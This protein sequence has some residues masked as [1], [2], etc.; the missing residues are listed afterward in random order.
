MTNY[1]LIES[2]DAFEARDNGGFCSDLAAS[3]S[4]RGNR[5]TVFAV[6][7]GVLSRREGAQVPAL[8]ALMRAGVNVQ[9]DSF[10]LRE[11]SIPAEALADG[12]VPGELDTVIDCLAAGWRVIWH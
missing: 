4:Q 8:T 5:V 11:R 10:S 7:N 1:L 6:Q 2:R 3:L 12:V 9:A